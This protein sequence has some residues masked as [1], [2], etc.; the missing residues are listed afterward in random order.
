MHSTAYAAEYYVPE[1][2]HTIASVFWDFMDSSGPIS[3][4]GQ[5]TEGRSFQ[6]PFFGFGFPVT[7]AY[8][9][10]IELDGESNRHV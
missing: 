5:I 10:T 2:S 3:V 6:D 8:W 7:G 9:S 1:T 4:D